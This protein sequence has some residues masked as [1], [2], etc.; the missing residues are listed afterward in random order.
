MRCKAI[1]LFLATLCA[2]QLARAEE[3]FKDNDASVVITSANDSAFPEISVDF[4]V[5]RPDGSFILEANKD[6]F[7]VTEDGVEVP[8]VSFLAPR[9]R[10]ARPITVVLVVDH[11]RSMQNHG[12]MTGLKRA[13]ASFLEELPEGSRVALIA[14]GSDVELS[15]PFTEDFDRVRQAVQQLQPTG[16]TRF[17]DAVAE[18][19]EI[20]SAEP[21]RRA[22]LALTD[23]EDTF[24]QTATPD[25]VVAA[26]RTAGLPIHTLG[27]GTEDSP[28]GEILRR[29][30]VDTRGQHYSTEDAGQ[31]RAIYEQIAERLRSSF[32][33]VYRT[34]RKIPDGTLRPVRVS[35]RGAR[36]AGET[37]VFIP[38]M[39]V[40]AGGW[41]GLFLAILATLALLAA[42]PG[43]ARRRHAA[44][45]D[46]HS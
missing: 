22:I 21:G 37:A 6:E 25:S 19:L 2:A 16:A 38:G 5:K 45:V 28:A 36:Q 30:A 18:A 39:V 29:M 32:T 14:F 24:S 17:F 27:L 11:S 42:L 10:E 41:P 23:G 34:E 35:Y 7:V 20:I 1:G 12:R 13:V 31:L 46:V 9:T 3:P 44:S 33:L 4:E 15:C 43:W 26:A 40:P 8:V